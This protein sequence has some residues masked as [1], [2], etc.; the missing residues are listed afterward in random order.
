MDGC[1]NYK[2][3]YY[4]FDKCISSKPQ[5]LYTLHYKL[6]I[7]VTSEN[8]WFYGH[9]C[10]HMQ[11]KQFSQN[12]C[13]KLNNAVHKCWQNPIHISIGFMLLWPL[14]R[15]YGLSCRLVSG[16]SQCMCRELNK[17]WKSVFSLSEAS[18]SNYKPAG[19]VTVTTMIKHVHT[20]DT[21]WC[22]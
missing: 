18:D 19:H 13:Y 17:T 3:L 15:G 10:S 5:N 9:K 6:F 14:T 11:H 1:K 12:L 4:I 16:H 7:E 8:V 20:Y 22:S 2:S 21:V